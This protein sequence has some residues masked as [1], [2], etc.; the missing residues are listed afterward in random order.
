MNE[1]FNEINWETDFHDKDVESN[2]SHLMSHVNNAQQQFVPKIIVNSFKHPIWLNKESSSLIKLKKKLWHINM[3]LKW[4]NNNLLAE[5]KKIKK[6]V[7]KTL[8]SSIKKFEES[9]ANDKK[10]PKRL[11]AY[12][13]SKQKIKS[14]INSLIIN[15]QEITTRT[16]IANALNNQFKSVFVNDAQSET[17]NFSQRTQTRIES[18]LISETL[19]KEELMKLQTNKSCGIDGLHPAILKQCALSLA[20]PL[21]LIFKQSF[22]TSKLPSTWLQANVTPLHKKGDKQDPANYRP[23]SLTSIACK[24]MERLVKNTITKHLEENNLTN[25]CQHGFVKYKACNTNLLETLDLVTSQLSK[26]TSIDIIFLDFEKAFDKVSHRLLLHKLEKYGITGKLLKWIK[27]FLTNRSQR[28]ILGDATSQWT[29]VTSG[30]PQGSVLGPLL[31]LLYIN[32]MPDKI[33]NVIKMYADDSKLISNG[34]HTCEMQNDLNEITQWT[35]DWL[36]QLNANKCK[37]MHIGKNNNKTHYILK[38]PGNNALDHTLEQTTSERD[39]GIQLDHKLSFEDQTS[40]AVGKANNMIGMFKRTFA[41]RDTKIWSKL[42][43]TYIRPHLEFA[44]PV[45]NPFKQKEIDKLEKVQRRVSKIPSQLRNL[46]YGERIKQMGLTSHENRR[47]RGELIQQYK[48]EN[49][50]DKINWHVKP[51]QSNQSGRLRRELVKNCQLRFNFFSNRIVNPW[52]ALDDETKNST[53][54]GMFK[55]RIDRTMG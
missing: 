49:G 15:N 7:R 42:Y 25:N 20:K 26:K 50:L 16:D 51:Q 1:Y 27:A 2:Y 45:W 11:F 3:S 47:H 54:I 21:S 24:I 35:Q 48:I 8:N 34:V 18:M 17:P 53:T 33:K 29:K 19:V 37:V 12:I 13:N 6:L 38:I 10:N 44:I 31:F 39:L 52:N 22:D 30:V 28:V 32:D 46:P 36:M 23:I 5:Y 41:T 40:K 9:L 4:K 55:A 14:T 43:K